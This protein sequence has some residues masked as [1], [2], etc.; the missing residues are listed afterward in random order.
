MGVLLVWGPSPKHALHVALSWR[1]ETSGGAGRSQWYG[2]IPARSGLGGALLFG[3][4][5]RL[6]PQSRGR[7]VTSASRCPCGP[8]DGSLWPLLCGNGHEKSPG[9]RSGLVSFGRTTPAMGIGSRR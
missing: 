6:F 1:R 2:A 5:R 4:L 3:R 7:S 9:F 8:A